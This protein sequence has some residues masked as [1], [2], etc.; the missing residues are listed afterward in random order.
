MT[1]LTEQLTHSFCG[2]HESTCCSAVNSYLALHDNV[3]HSSTTANT[4]LGIIMHMYVSFYSRHG[5]SSI[6]TMC[7][8]LVILHICTRGRNP[9][10]LTLTATIDCHCACFKYSAYVSAAAQVPWV[11]RKGIELQIK[12][13]HIL[14]GTVKKLFLRFSLNMVQRKVHGILNWSRPKEMGHAQD[15]V[16]HHITWHHPIQFTYSHVTI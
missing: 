9:N 16:R 10:C 13:P 15:H 12:W 3:L 2:N 7:P 4:A 11:P 5:L 14:H 1:I 6:F 8:K